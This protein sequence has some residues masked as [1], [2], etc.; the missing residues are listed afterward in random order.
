MTYGYGY[1]KIKSEMHATSAMVGVQAV[2]WSDL[3]PHQAGGNHS[4]DAVPVV[5]VGSTCL[6]THLL[7]T[8]KRYPGSPPIHWFAS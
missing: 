4:L 8:G 2:T 1:E 5:N 7:Y 6:F 3:V